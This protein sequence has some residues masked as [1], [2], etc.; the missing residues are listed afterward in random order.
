M[1]AT[2]AALAGLFASLLAGCG[3]AHPSGSAPSQAEVS[4]LLDRHARAVMSHSAAQFMSD[5]DPTA[6]AAA[7]RHRQDT[8]FTDLAG[9][10]LATWTYTVSS[11]VTDVDATAE[12]AKRL[13]APALIVHVTLG[14]ALDSVDPRPVA[15]DLWWTFVKRHGRVYV[16]ADD[17]MAQLGGLG[18]QGPWDFGPVV[19]HR[20]ASSLVLGHPQDAAELAGLATAVDAALSQVTA[21][22]GPQWSRQVAVVVPAS[23]AEY[24]ALGGTATSGPSSDA[25]GSLADISAETVFESPNTIGTDPSG[26]RVIL[27]PHTLAALTPL[28]QRIVLRHEIAHV[29]AASSTG[30]GT[31]RWLVEGLAEYVANLDSGQSVATAAV[32]LR[33]EVSRAQVPSA[34]PAD[35]DF[36]PGAARLAAVYEQ[37]WL[38]CRLIAARAGSA[39]LVRFYRIVG[40]SG[41]TPAEA[42]SAAV[43]AV[44]RE[45]VA[46][47][48]AQWRAYL[49]VQ[50]R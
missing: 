16:G 8:E 6:A 40:E 46:T 25:A 32:E 26:A 29:A 35:G 41:L 22:W 14:Y 49:I 38:A 47:F 9:V 18:W 21:A 50:L 7:F 48:T 27:N 11:P 45:T 44:L 31:P 4:A 10:P 37:S 15:H 20:G 39:G 34:L 19:A 42:V 13:G 17:D 36:R 3:A 30:I 24:A 12:A 23:D 43:R 5:V 33:A 2:V 28:G 1:P